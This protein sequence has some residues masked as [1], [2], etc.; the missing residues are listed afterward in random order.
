LNSFKNEKTNKQLYLKE[1]LSISKMHNII[2]DDELINQNNLNGKINVAYIKTDDLEN[3]N[4][5]EQDGKV[6][7]NDNAITKDDSK[8]EI[9]TFKVLDGN[10]SLIIN[11]I[12]YICLFL[13]LKIND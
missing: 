11:I 2:Y 13:N 9:S 7:I 4:N 1:K 6:I 5:N 10:T 3:S 12:Y 8:D